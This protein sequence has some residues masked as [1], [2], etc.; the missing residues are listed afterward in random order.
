MTVLVSNTANYFETTLT[1]SVGPTDLVYPVN[2]TANG[3]TS[4][5]YLEF[6]PDDPTKREIILCD[7]TFDA[8]NFR[9]SA[10]GK[11]YLSGSAAASGLTHAIGTVVRCGPVSQ[12]MVDLHDRVTDLDTRSVLKSGFVAKGDLMTATAA[13]ITARFPVGAN[14]TVLEADSTTSLGWKS[15]TAKI[16]KD[17]LTTKG[18]L[19]AATGS[20]VPARLAA[21]T[22]N[23]V[24]R[25][26]AAAAAGVEYALVDANSL[27]S[28]LSK[29]VIVAD[30]TARD[31]L[32]PYTG[33]A[34]VVKD[35][36]L[37]EGIQIY[38]SANQWRRPWNLPW[39]QVA[40]AS[41][42]LD[43][44]S[45]G[46]FADFVSATVDIIAGRRYRYTLMTGVYSSVAN[47]IV[48]VRVST[49][50][51]VD[52]CV[53]D[54]YDFDCQTLLTPITFI[55]TET[56]ATTALATTRKV[57]LLRAQGT[58]SV[59]LRADPATRVAVLHIDDVGPGGPPA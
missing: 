39:G 28:T 44:T 2:T 46:S 21:G 33:L 59:G 25:A 29:G 4:P 54:V 24:L 41:T 17:L 14:E 20:A 27:A 32:T 34:V 35:N 52:V 19:I 51:N 15:G 50:A 55:C 1:S 38:N 7:S 12:H 13:G 31:A 42:D 36:T 3:P 6:N 58:G 40:T 56:A 8:T 57:R 11:R 26:K 9:S 22:D 16:S 48:R 47:D 18:D 43:V 45:S 53:P 23:H 5:A 49:G 10:I 30:T 37:S